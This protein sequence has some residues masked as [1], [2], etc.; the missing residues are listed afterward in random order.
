MLLQE[1]VTQ[2]LIVIH[3]HH[4]TSLT[5]STAKWILG[6]SLCIR[7]DEQEKFAICR[8]G[9]SREIFYQVIALEKRKSGSYKSFVISNPDSEIH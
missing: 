6:L 3:P 4:S 1:F 5:S 9:V 2:D 8:V 7:S